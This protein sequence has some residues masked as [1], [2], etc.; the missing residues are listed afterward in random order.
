M[1]TTK[2]ACVPFPIQHHL[3]RFSGMEHIPS[4]R[5][6]QRNIE[7]IGSEL[8]IYY[9]KTAIHLSILLVMDS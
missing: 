8:P 2:R 3:W 6:I 7:G 9:M 5:Q 1:H 4:V